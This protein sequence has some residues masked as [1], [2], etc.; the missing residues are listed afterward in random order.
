MT[1]VAHPGASEGL[2]T[3]GP[4]AV[5]CGIK[6]SLDVEHPATDVPEV[7]PLDSLIYIVSVS[8]FVKISDKI[9]LLRRQFP[10]CRGPNSRTFALLL[11]YFVQAILLRD[12]FSKVGKHLA[13]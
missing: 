4:N 3:P 2:G 11:K 10:V 9:K 5:P 7:K 13:H 6:T 12:E 8:G 1:R